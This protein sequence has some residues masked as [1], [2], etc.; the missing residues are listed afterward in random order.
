MKIDK[1]FATLIFYFFKISGFAP[2]SF[3]SV[4]KSNNN[5]DRQFTIS[6]TS[7]IYNLF[8]VISML[9][10]SLSMD[11]DV[12]YY[13]IE[14]CW[15]LIVYMGKQTYFILTSITILLLYVFKRE[16]IVLLANKMKIQE[17]RTIVK[18]RIALTKIAKIFI[19]CQLFHCFIFLLWQFRKKF[20]QIY[21]LRE[22][23]SYHVNCV[24]LMQYSMVLILLKQY[25]VNVNREI[26]L[27]FTKKSSSNDEIRSIFQSIVINKKLSKLRNRHL[28]LRELSSEI[29]N[30]YSLPMLF[31][32]INVIM[33]IIVNVF[34]SLEVLIQ[35]KYDSDNADVVFCLLYAGLYTIL[36]IILTKNVSATINEVNYVFYN[37][38][39]NTNISE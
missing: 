17:D 20:S 37:N 26:S 21:L 6:K 1:A 18:N 4:P 33:I 24:L 2:L 3:K 35:K 13:K 25:F 38:I 7:M 27:I 10:L 29:S 19:P 39:F 31:N 22:C 14:P 11:V 23:F 32:S 36:F 30:F 16:K 9:S 34:Y 12:K 15:E 5:Y 8:F 28:L